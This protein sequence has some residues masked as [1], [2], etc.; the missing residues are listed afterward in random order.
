MIPCWRIRLNW[1]IR[2]L[3][4]IKRRRDAANAILNF[5]AILENKKEHGSLTPIN[6]GHMSNYLLFSVR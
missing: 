4:T 3:K 2:N 5:S 6:A 1:A